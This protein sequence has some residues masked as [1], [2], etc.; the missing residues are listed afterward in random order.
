MSNPFIIS[1]NE[2][3]LAD[4]D[5]NLVHGAAW[6]TVNNLSVRIHATDEGVVCDVYPKGYEMEDSIAS[7]YAF[8]SEGPQNKE[9]A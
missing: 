9:A 1:H 6:L 4:G 2:V 7:C 3:D 5:Y 8:F